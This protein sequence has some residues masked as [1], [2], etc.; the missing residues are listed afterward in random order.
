VAPADPTV[1][2]VEASPSAPPA[3]DTVVE[4]RDVRRRFA[5]VEALRGLDLDVHRG[6]ITVL[7][8]PNGA[9]KTTAIRVITGALGVDH[10]TVRVFGLDPDVPARGEEVRR[11][12]GVVSA[13]PALYDRLSGFDNLRYSAELY[14]LGW[15]P[16][17]R[18]RI[19]EAA[20]RFGI[21]SS[22]DAQVGGY[23]TGMKTRLALARSVLHRPDLLLFDEPTSGLDPE[24]SHAVLSMIKEMALDGTTV[25]MCTHLL[26]EAEGLAEQVV[27]MEAGRDI[28][29]GRPAD[30]IRQHWPQDEVRLAAEDPSSL[31]VARD[32][33][34]VRALRPAPEGGGAVDVE[35]DDLRRVP[36]IVLALTT[37]GVRL[38]EV[39]PHDRSLEELYFAVRAPHIGAAPLPGRGEHVLA[40]G[41]EVHVDGRTEPQTEEAPVP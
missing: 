17:T 34:G 37:R 1:R 11:R 31:Q 24:S 30:L 40:P 36:E 26:L 15:S 7:L 33:P 2:A 20:T 18:D 38:T 23:S 6:T 12:C 21:H 32:L 4:L 35:V 5:R 13:K 29:A 28:A 41:V 25:I 10:G 8:G 27:V 9:G 3:G 16:E 19:I 39:T 14:G 22:L